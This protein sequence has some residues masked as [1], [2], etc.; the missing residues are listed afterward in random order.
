MTIKQILQNSK[1]I[2]VIGC[3]KD[4]MRTSHHIAK[5]IK[6]QDYRMIPV[7]PD[8]EEVLEEKVYGSVKDIP[9]DVTIDIVDIFRNPK[10]TADMVQEVIERVD[11]TGEKPVIWTQLGVSSEEARKKAEAAGLPYVEE[12]CL[13]VE[14]QRKIAQ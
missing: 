13:M 1:T 5:Y 7:H 14:H 4:R 8:Y 12:K 9:A 11:Q 10:F 3:S 6:E 2:A